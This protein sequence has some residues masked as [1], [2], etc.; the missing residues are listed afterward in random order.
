MPQRWV[1][2]R[3]LISVGLL[4][5]A[6]LACN[7]QVGSQAPTSTVQ[8]AS[9]VF[10][11]PEN[12]ASVAEGASITFA[13]KATDSSGIAKVEFTIDDTPLGSQ[14][15]NSTQTTFT[16]R[17]PWK[18]AE[19]RGHLVNAIAFRADGT[20]IGNANLT[21]N[22]V[23]AVAMANTN[24]VQPTLAN[25]P[26]LAPTLPPPTNPPPPTI[27]ATILGV[28]PT[29]NTA[30]AATVQIVGVRVNVRSGPGTN[31]QIIG[32]MKTGDSAPIIGRNTDSTW[33]AIQFNQASGWVINNQE[34]VKVSGDTSQVHLAQ[35]AASPV[36]PTATF[37]QSLAPTSTVGPVAD[38]VFGDV[39]LNPTNPVANETFTITAVIRN[40]GTIDANSSYLA[41]IFQ[42]GNEKSDTSVPP[43]KAGESATVYWYVTLKSGGANQAG[44]LTLDARN[45]VA[46]GTVGEANNVKTIPYNVGG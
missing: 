24:S 29:A 22:V 25:L 32:E 3:A 18:A 39:T 11:G 14:N 17:Q 33:W 35:S 27:A 37:V 41:G 20:P 2:V 26:T 8:A 38:L 46:E 10:I 36:P 15:S 45:E 7:M 1:N 44:Q 6:S 30:G 13:V 34:L 16:A 40:Q 4:I 23:Q 43:I 21:I 19:I 31:F 12:N 42:P 5:T 9:V 28:P